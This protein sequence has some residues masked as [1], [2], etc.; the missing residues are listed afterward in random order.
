MVDR[1][2]RGLDA[3]EAQIYRIESPLDLADLKELHALD[4][5]DLKFEPWLPV[6][7]PRL[8]AA[9]A[10]AP[11]IFDD[12]RRADLAVHQP[13]ESFRGSFE[14]LAQ[15]AVQDPDVIAMKTAVYRT[16]DDSVL[17]ASLIQCAEE[18]KQSVCLVE[19][20]ARFDERRKSSGHELSSRPGSTS[21]TGSRTSRS[22]Q[23]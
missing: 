2:T 8:E 23:R 6:I 15:A 10:D 18:G 14:V 1:L 16:S 17:V 9:Q 4:R 7:P 22:T 3:D 20:K 5:P 21:P 19:L 11:R 12:I 13:Y